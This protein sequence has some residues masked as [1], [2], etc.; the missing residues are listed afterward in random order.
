MS[1]FDQHPG[2]SDTWGLS[3]SLDQGMRAGEAP[4]IALMRNSWLRRSAFFLVELSVSEPSGRV[5]HAPV[6]VLRFLLTAGWYDPGCK[7]LHPKSP[8][9]NT[10]HQ[11][12]SL[13]HG[14]WDHCA[15]ELTLSIRWNIP[16]HSPGGMCVRRNHNWVVDPM[17]VSLHRIAGQ[18]EQAWLTCQAAR[19]EDAAT[20]F[21]PRR[22]RISGCEAIP[23]SFGH[24]PAPKMRGVSPRSQPGLDST[25]LVQ[26]L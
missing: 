2:A 14:I 20:V 4:R 6:R 3:P 23:S 24:R 9:H 17:R 15:L 25:R 26:L 5:T 10:L 13:T 8:S 22:Y 7:P 21:R 11:S 12:E 1:K 18:G 19:M 16:F